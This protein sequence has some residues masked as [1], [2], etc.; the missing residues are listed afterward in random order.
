MQSCWGWECFGVKPR[1]WE[2]STHWLHWLSYI[3]KPEIHSFC[4]HW[5]PAEVLS[6]EAIIQRVALQRRL[7]SEP[8]LRVF[9]IIL[10]HKQD[11]NDKQDAI[12]KSPWIQ[13]P[14]RITWPWALWY[15][16]SQSH[17]YN[18]RAGSTHSVEPWT[19]PGGTGHG[20]QRAA[21]HN[22]SCLQNSSQVKTYK[23][24]IFGNIYRLINQANNGK[25]KN[26]VGQGWTWL[27]SILTEHLAFVWCNKGSKAS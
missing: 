7:E 20:A 25:Q 11:T 1:I 26:H 13:S 22:T 5:Q 8:S 27:T 24:V 18:W 12:I 2:V 17:Y 23:L 15:C 3:P 14:E 19:E 6:D 21:W 16:S 10:Q 4:E 9:H